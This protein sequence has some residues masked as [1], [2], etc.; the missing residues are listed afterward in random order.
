MKNFYEEN[1]SEQGSI[2]E[3]EDDEK[4]LTREERSFNLMKQKRHYDQKRPNLII[5]CGNESRLL[6]SEIRMKTV[7]KWLCKRKT[8]VN[9]K[10]YLKKLYCK[11]DFKYFSLNLR[12]H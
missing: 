5:N 7:G 9:Q 10:I 1:E 8:R 4:A 12:F 3:S 2:E 11:V 6:K